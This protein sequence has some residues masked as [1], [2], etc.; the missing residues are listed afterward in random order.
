[1]SEDAPLFVVPESGWGVGWEAGAV[2][3]LPS[4]RVALTLKESQL[5][6][7]LRINYESGYT[8]L[9]DAHDYVRDYVSNQCSNNGIISTI[10]QSIDG[11][12]KGLME[13]CGVRVTEYVISFGEQVFVATYVN[14]YVNDGIPSIKVFS[15]MN[16]IEIWRNSIA[17]QNWKNLFSDEP[18]EVGLADEYFERVSEIASFT[19][20]K[21]E[22]V[23]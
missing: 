1:M 10:H 18:P 5:S 7:C 4:A 8:P 3:H 23:I 15:N 21:A 9:S 19:V 13:N 17:T 16:D 6:L 12:L 11:M 22:L 2:V 20:V 14:E